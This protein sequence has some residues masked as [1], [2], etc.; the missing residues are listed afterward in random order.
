MKKII[1][2][3]F[4]IFL[5]VLSGCDF[6]LSQSNDKDKKIAELQKQVEELKKDKEDDLFKKKQEC[7]KLEP[8]IKK[9]IND[10]YSNLSENSLNKIFYSPVL[11]SCLYTLGISY[12]DHSYSSIINYFTR[13]AILDSLCYYEMNFI[14]C[15][16]NFQ[17]KIDKFEWIEIW[18]GINAKV[19]TGN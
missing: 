9:Q 11:N 8:E 1:V 17:K 3:I 12:Q 16:E 15:L 5:I 2:L 18:T 13:E 14:E 4:S 19:W 10:K 6:N 7:I